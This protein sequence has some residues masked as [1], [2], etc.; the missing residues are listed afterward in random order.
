MHWLLEGL[1]LCAGLFGL[2]LVILIW[3]A[4]AYYLS[5]LLKTLM[6]LLSHFLIRWLVPPLLTMHLLLSG[7]I[8]ALLL[9]QMR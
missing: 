6:H 5:I 8:T 9:Y 2:A 1:S 4:V 3:A 7:N